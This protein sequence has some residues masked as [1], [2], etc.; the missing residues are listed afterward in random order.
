MLRPKI[1]IEPAESAWPRR[2]LRR[3]GCLERTARIREWLAGNPTAEQMQAVFKELSG[4][5]KGAAKLLR[6]RVGDRTRATPNRLGIGLTACKGS[7]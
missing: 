6:V 4:K 3:R 5:D 2:Q 1:G 7:G